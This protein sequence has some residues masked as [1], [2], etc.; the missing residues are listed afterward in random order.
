MNIVR[1]ALCGFMVIIAV[2]ACTGPQTQATKAEPSER[3]RF[4]GSY[5]FDGERRAINVYHVVDHQTGR[6]FISVEGSNLVEVA[7]SK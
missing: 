4:T 3:S 5:T 2:A 1:N 7:A 6:E